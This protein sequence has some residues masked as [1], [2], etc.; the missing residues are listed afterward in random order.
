MIFLV[1][2]IVSLFKLYGCVVPL[3]YVIYSVLLMTK[4]INQMTAVEYIIYTKE[5]E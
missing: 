5:K 4:F 1:Y 2:S 3:S